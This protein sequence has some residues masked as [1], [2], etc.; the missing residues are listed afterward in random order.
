MLILDK[1]SFSHINCSN[2]L[3]KEIYKK[4]IAD[5]AKHII[6]IPPVVRSNSPLFDIQISL[7]RTAMI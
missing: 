2:K 7:I 6:V 4:N 1:H 5:L 3:V